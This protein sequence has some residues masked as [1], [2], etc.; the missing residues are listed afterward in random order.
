MKNIQKIGFLGLILTI[1]VF[2]FGEVVLAQNPPQVQTISATTI[3][4]NSVT[5]NGNITYLGDYGMRQFISNGELV[6]PM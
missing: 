3:Q 6:F 2:C 1:S 4:N 5:L